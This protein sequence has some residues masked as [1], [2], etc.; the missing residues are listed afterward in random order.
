MKYMVELPS[1]ASFEWDFLLIDTP[2]GEDLILGF[3]FLNVFNPSMY[4]K[5]GLITFNANQKDYYYPPNSF[6]NAFS[7]KSCAALSLPSSG[8]KISKDIQDFGAD[9]S[10][11]SPHLFFGNMDLLRSFHHDSL[12]GL[13]DEQEEPQEIENMRKVVPSVYHQYLNVFS[14]LKAEKLPPHR[15]CD[16]HIKLEGSLPPRKFSAG[17]APLQGENLSSLSKR[18]MVASVCVLITANSMLATTTSLTLLLDGCGNPTWSQVGANWSRHI[19]YGQLAPLGV[20][21][22]LRHSPFQ[23]PFTAS[24]HILPSLAFLANFHLT[25]P[26]A[27]TLD[28]GPGGSPGPLSIT[29]D[30]GPPPFIR[31]V[32]A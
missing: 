31:G 22:L 25:N 8:D 26:Q 13:W 6:T 3:D 2:K 21:W 24:G 11:S 27:F 7:S 10:V 28:F 15:A 17:Q 18:K 16:H 32:E 12:E 30:F 14:K 9:S 20:L 23:W 19:V 4:W 1:F 29:L 5:Q